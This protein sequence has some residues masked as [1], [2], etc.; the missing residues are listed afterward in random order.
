M[1]DRRF[2]TMLDPFHIKYGNGVACPFTILS[3]IS[4]LI[5]L[6]TTLI[7]LGKLDEPDIHKNRVVY[8]INDT[9]WSY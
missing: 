8:S 5:W 9:Q 6:P 3:L 7:P 1:R 4:D 2:V